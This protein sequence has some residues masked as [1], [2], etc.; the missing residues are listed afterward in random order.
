MTNLLTGRPLEG[1][2]AVVTGASS[3]M[4]EATAR[5][6]AELG[7]SVEVIARRRER[8]ASLAAGITAGGGNALRLSVDVTDRAAVLRA[9]PGVLSAARTITTWAR[10]R[11]VT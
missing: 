1:R 9:T 2:V 3:G 11:N 8:L 10:V 5:R 7:A 4:G 6:L